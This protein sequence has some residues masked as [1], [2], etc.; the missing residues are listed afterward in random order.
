MPQVLL[1]GRNL[2]R[3]AL[4]Y[5]F[6]YQSAILAHQPRLARS[7]SPLPWRYSLRAGQLSGGDWGNGDGFLGAPGRGATIFNGIIKTCGRRLWRQPQATGS[8]RVQ[9][10]TASTG[11]RLAETIWVAT[12]DLRLSP[13]A[14]NFSAF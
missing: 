13:F 5:R 9:R 12:F 6:L 3:T 7:P 11:P 8:A 2:H 1:D 10:A 14:F 4:A